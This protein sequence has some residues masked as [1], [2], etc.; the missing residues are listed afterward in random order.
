MFPAARD[1]LR[2]FPARL[3]THIDVIPTF[4]PAEL[5][6]LL[7]DCALGVFPSYLEGFGFAVLEMLA[8]SLPVVAYDVPG[9]RMMLDRQYLVPPGNVDVLTARVLSLLCNPPQLLRA[10]VDARR[11]A[12]RFRWDE[13]GART[14]SVYEERL[15]RL[16]SGVAA[17]GSPTASRLQT[18]EGVV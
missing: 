9:P 4:D 15:A 6:R 1:V 11:T 5:P 12:D 13:I 7:E 14:A 18:A 3:R 8:A 10:R 2:L 17:G 16:R